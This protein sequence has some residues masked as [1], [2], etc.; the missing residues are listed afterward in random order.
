[1]E[2]SRSGASDFVANT[3][4]GRS[5]VG[6]GPTGTR[7]RLLKI[8]YLVALWGNGDERSPRGVTNSVAP[9]G[10]RRRG[11]SLSGLPSTRNPPAVTASGSLLHRSSSSSPEGQL[12]HRRRLKLLLLQ[13]LYG[14]DDRLGP[15][16]DPLRDPVSPLLDQRVAPPEGIQQQRPRQQQSRCALHG[17]RSAGPA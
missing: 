15:T 10:L 8:F 1:M 11:G 9:Q 3:R 14:V 5:F 4:A 6:R 16:L 12:W 17:R 2:C 13:S 7:Q